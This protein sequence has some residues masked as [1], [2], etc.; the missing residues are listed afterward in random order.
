MVSAIS[1]YKNANNCQT[2]SKVT[3]RDRKT[4]VAM[5]DKTGTETEVAAEATEAA[6]GIDKAV[7][8]MEEVVTEVVTVV[9][10]TA[11]V[12][13]VSAEAEAEVAADVPEIKMHQS[14]SET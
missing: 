3:A 4:P 2:S 6:M 8:A 9:A 1:K 5:A 13:A 14:S 12:A 10:V 11:E 7:A